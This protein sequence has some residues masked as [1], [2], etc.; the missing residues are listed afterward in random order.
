M[1]DQPTV[2]VLCFEVNYRCAV[3]PQLSYC[4]CLVNSVGYTESASITSYLGRKCVCASRCVLCR[5]VRRRVG[6]VAPAL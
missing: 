2:T 5:S 3:I 6:Q 1:S 4:K